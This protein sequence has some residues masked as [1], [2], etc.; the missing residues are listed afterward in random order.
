MCMFN[1]RVWMDFQEVEWKLRAR[2]Q[3]A[4]S[5]RRESAVLEKLRTEKDNLRL[6][7]RGSRR[8]GPVVQQQQQG[9]CGSRLFARRSVGGVE[10]ASSELRQAVAP[11]EVPEQQQQW[12]RGGGAPQQQGCPALPS[13]PRRPA[14]WEH[15]EFTA[16]YDEWYREYSSWVA[17]QHLQQQRSSPTR[18]GW[19]SPSPPPPPPPPPLPQRH[20]HT[21]G[22]SRTG[23]GGIYDCGTN[24]NYYQPETRPPPHASRDSVCVCARCGRKGHIAE[25]CLAR[26]RFEG[27]MMCGQRG[28]TS[29]HCRLSH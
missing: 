5:V 18:G 13:Q 17:Q 2:L 28:H 7:P 14:P 24:A 21:A 16:A 19:T 4:Q 11:H 26:K 1:K 22:V 27:E 29:R 6:L 8:A 23:A 10:F 3:H 12:S 15:P 20:P 9:V 25:D